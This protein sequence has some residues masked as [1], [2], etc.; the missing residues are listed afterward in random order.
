MAIDH[1]LSR[2]EFFEKLFSAT[3]LAAAAP[4]VVLGKSIPS[5]SIRNNELLGQ[6]ALKISQYAALQQTYKSLRIKITGMPTSF[7]KILV[8]RVENN[9]FYAVSEK[10]THEGT[11][12]GDLNATTRIFTCPSHFSEFNPDGTVVQGPAAR[13]LTKYTTTYDGN[14]TVLIEIPGLTSAVPSD[15]HGISFLLHG[16]PIQGSSMATVSYGI[17]SSAN[18]LLAIYSSNGTEVRR[19]VDGFED[20]GSYRLPYDISGLP[21]GIYFY[22]LECSTGQV[23]TEKFMIVR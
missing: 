6:Y 14:D 23:R 4:A 1:I 21:N 12:V 13:A 11:A 18:V 19:L 10:C 22:R 9:V 7:G 2:R 20:A 8:T 16:T 3:V 17:E 5:L 15:L